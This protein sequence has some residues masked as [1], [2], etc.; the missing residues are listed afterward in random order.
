MSIIK[1]STILAHFKIALYPCRITGGN[2]RSWIKTIALAKDRIS[3]PT[4]DYNINLFE[5]MIS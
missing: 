5:V 3:G 2:G 1:E 4:D